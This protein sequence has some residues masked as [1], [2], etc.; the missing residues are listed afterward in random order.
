M[1]AGALGALI[2]LGCGDPPPSKYPDQDVHVEDATFGPGDVFEVRVFVGSKETSTVYR[3][4]QT[5]TINFLYIGKV[6]VAGKDPSDVEE[7]IRTRLADGYLRDPIVSIFVK[8]RNSKKVSV[9]GEVRTPGTFAYADGMTVVDAIAQAG[10]F[11][12]MARKN[13]VTVTRA[14][15][16]KKMRYTVPVDDIGKGKAA[17]FLIRPGDV[18]FAPERPY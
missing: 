15:D 13:A 17:N 2:A 8:E 12:P 5:G 9:F 16:G 1:M 14:D 10:G 4:S 6:A 11:S 18:V 7:E 3:V